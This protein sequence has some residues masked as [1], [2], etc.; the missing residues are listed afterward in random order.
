MDLAERIRNAKA[1]D[2]EK[3][4][5]EKAKAKAYLESLLTKVE[6][7]E[8]RITKLIDTAND[9]LANGFWSFLDPGEWGRKGF[10]S[11]GW[12]HHFGLMLVEGGWRKP[13][14][15]RRVDSVGIVNGGA[16][17]NYDFH[18]T[19]K[20][21]YMTEWHR[22]TWTNQPLK[23]SSIER[24]L[25]GFEDFESRFYSELETFLTKKGA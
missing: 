21:H 8:P 20:C 13:I 23:V 6:A 19:G 24:M 4:L 25:D 12:A 5:D 3:A 11:E 15:E 2:I 17:G 7:L 1:N 18:T 9:L 14:N 22:S 10:V 16:C